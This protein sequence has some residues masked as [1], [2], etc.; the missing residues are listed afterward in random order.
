MSDD[1]VLSFRT[2]RELLEATR[3]FT[4][5]SRIRSWWYVG[6]TLTALVTVLALTTCWLWWPLRCALS[7][8]GGLLI[9][10]A[11]ILFHD[12]LHG[13]LLRKSPFAKGLFY[14]FGMI[15]LTPPRHWRRSHNFHH[16]HVGKPI[17]PE[18]GKFSLL[19]S[20]VGSFGLMT[21]EMWESSSNWQRWHYRI[22]RHFLTLAFAYI[23]VFLGS[24][25]IAPLWNHPR[26][27]WE[28]VLAILTHG[29][30]IA[31]LW[32]YGGF[33]TAFFAFLLPFAIA[34]ASGAYLFAAQHNFE[35][36]RILEHDDWN[37]YRGSLESSSY[38]K[39]GPI[40]SWFTANIGY[41][42]VHHLNSLIPFYRLP[43]A[44]AAIPELQQPT[45]TSLRPPDVLSC[46]RLHL[47]DPQTQRLVTYREAK[48]MSQP[49]KSE[50]S[51]PASAVVPKPLGR[52]IP[53]QP[54][55]RH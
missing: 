51:R 12:F 17:T 22:S 25:C 55:G 1:P 52:S 46:L 32:S 39:L 19:T 9:V 11:F 20:N 36:L 31:A 6:S 18:A 35:G 37:Y 42:H 30:I 13:A 16:A 47:W 40:M 29:G 21:I 3:P 5:E 14:V 53:Q 28:G 38:L 2:G 48:D 54:A 43:E 23:T 10:R 44:M 41:H 50:L 33:A 15:V 45:I 49:M 4:A 8:L 26:K 7:I 34:A 24:L 27:N